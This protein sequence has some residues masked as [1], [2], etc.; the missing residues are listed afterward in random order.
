MDFTK[1]T[2]NNIKLI[3]D[4]ILTEELTEEGFRRSIKSLCAVSLMC[5]DLYN[6]FN[7]P[8]EYFTKAHNMFCE[9][10]A[11]IYHRYNRSNPVGILHTM[12]HNF[13]LFNEYF[14]AELKKRQNQNELLEIILVMSFIAMNVSTNFHTDPVNIMTYQI[15]IAQ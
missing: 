7:N 5:V 8:E 14:K 15:K 12:R 13:N 9:T 2:L 3:C 4:D 11:A 6:L 1:N 10:R